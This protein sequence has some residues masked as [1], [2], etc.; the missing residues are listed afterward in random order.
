MGQSKRPTIKETIQ[1]LHRTITFA[2]ENGFVISCSGKEIYKH[3]KSTITEI[4]FSIDKNALEKYEQ[5]AKFL[6]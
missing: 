6:A 3:N 1:S 2:M 5:E 4:T